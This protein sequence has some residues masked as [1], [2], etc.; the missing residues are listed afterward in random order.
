MSS[1]DARFR[2]AYVA[3]VNCRRRKVKCVP[4]SEND[5]TQPCVRCQRKGLECESAL[6]QK[7][8]D[9][10]RAPARPTPSTSSGHS[11][12]RSGWSPQ[13]SHPSNMHPQTG[14]APIPL[15]TSGANNNNLMYGHHG[16]GH[17]HSYPSPSPYPPS[18]SA[19]HRPSHSNVN[20]PA[21]MQMDYSAPGQTFHN[22]RA[23]QWTNQQVVSNLYGSNY[24]LQQ[25]AVPPQDGR[26]FPYAQ[27]QWVQCICPPTGPCTCG[28]QFNNLQL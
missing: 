17:H 28:A 6:A 21:S 23:P 12:P 22:S 13:P 1:P 11:H 18:Q 15:P 5:W 9:L 25:A 14:F 3:C 7:P 8:D 10:A 24:N 16:Q 2:R 27:G 4:T 26:A 19:H 20:V